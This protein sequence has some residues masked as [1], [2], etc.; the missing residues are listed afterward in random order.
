MVPKPT[1]DSGRTP[2]A[3]VP[4]VVA[5]DL[6]LTY[7]DHIAVR[8]ASFELHPGTTA[9]IGPNGSGK[10]TLLRAISGLQPIRSGSL[11]VHGRPAGRDHRCVAHVLQ[12]TLVNDALPLTVLEVVRMGRYPVLGAFRRFTADDRE[13]VEEAMER[14]AITDLASRQLRDLS[15]GQQ[16]RAF[17]AQGLAQR[18]EVLLLDEPITGLD[19]PSQERIERVVAEEAAAGVAVV[20]TTHDVATAAAADQVLL[21]A[22][23][24]VA[25]G[26]PDEVL[27][28][29]HLGHAYGGTAF[30]TADGAL[31][32]AD[33]HIHGAQITGHEHH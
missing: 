6:L 9:I 15:G 1:P 20:L 10:S 7:D 5:R 33:P 14:L 29:E 18:A 12:S 25:I 26:P 17:V 16:Q 31:V 13:A 19:L 32:I 21:L 2:T 8:D 30:R 27:T 23:H 3:R 28:E 24:V 4:E 11:T 22:T